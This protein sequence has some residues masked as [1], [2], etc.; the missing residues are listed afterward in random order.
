MFDI[1]HF[2]VYIHET[3]AIIKLT[4]FKVF[5]NWKTE[6]FENLWQ[7]IVI[8]N[9]TF[10]VLLELM[11]KKNHNEFSFSQ[12]NGKKKQQSRNTIVIPHLTFGDIVIKKNFH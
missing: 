7:S 10:Q 2:L 12:Y 5:L 9:Y 3:I 1:H 4:K 6:S 8:L 11:Q